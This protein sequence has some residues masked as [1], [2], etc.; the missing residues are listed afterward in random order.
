ME[1]AKY[2]KMSDLVGGQFKVTACGGYKWKKWDTESNRMV[3]SE[4]YEKGFQKRYPLETDKGLLDVSASQLGAMYEGASD[5]GRSNIV[6]RSFTVKSN[7]KTG[8]EIRY[9]LNPVWEEPTIN[10]EEPINLDDV[11]GFAQD[12]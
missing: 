4:K 9:Y 2:T 5:L 3:V 6:G 12:D 7:G 10:I 8:M 11:P 1:K